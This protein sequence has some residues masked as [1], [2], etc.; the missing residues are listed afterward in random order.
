MF[1]FHREPN[2]SFWCHPVS[3]QTG[4][5][6]EGPIN[7]IAIMKII[8]PK[9]TE[10]NIIQLANQSGYLPLNSLPKSLFILIETVNSLL[11]FYCFSLNKLKHACNQF[12][13]DEY[14][15]V[16]NSRFKTLSQGTYC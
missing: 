11:P 8:P 13:G 12:E 1:F 2:S 15:K 6:T 16:Q 5:Q 4:K 9:L 10:V 14:G 3:K 7:R